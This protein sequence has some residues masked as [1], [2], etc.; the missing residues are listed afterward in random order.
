MKQKIIQARPIFD[1][2]GRPGGYT[3]DEE[4]NKLLADGWT[5]VQFYY[6]TVGATGGKDTEGRQGAV[7]VLIQNLR[8]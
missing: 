5:V 3:F 8:E 1:G 2:Y 4:I 7:F 6:P